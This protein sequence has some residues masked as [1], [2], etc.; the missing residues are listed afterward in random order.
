M[1]LKLLILVLCLQIYSAREA[2]DN[3]EQRA[4][5]VRQSNNNLLLEAAR[6]QN[7]TLRLMGESATVTVNGVDMVSLLRR[8][9]KIIVDRQ[10]AA[11]REPLSVE[12]VKDQFRDVERRMARI[13][14]RVFNARNSTRRSGLKQRTLRQQLQKVERVSGILRTLSA[15]LAKN[16]CESNPC[17]NG[18]TC[19]DAY[20]G[21]QCE[22][23]AGWQGVTCEDDVNECFT[24]AGT[25]L[26]GC[27]N[28]GQCINTPGSY[29][30]ICRNGFSG[31]HCRLRHNTCWASGSRELC[32][33]HGTCL[34]ASNSAGYVCICDQGWTWADPNAT[35]ASPSACTRDVD[36]CEPRVNPCHDVCINLPGSFRCGPCPPGYTGDGRFCQDIDECAGEDNGGCS[37]EPRVTC[38]NTEGSHR[39][40][41]CPIGWTGDGRTCTARNSNSCDQEKIC[42]PLAKCEYVSDTVVCTC[43]LGSYGHGYGAEGCTSDSGRLPCDQHPC[44]NNGTCVQNGRGTTC[45]CQPGYMGALCNSSD[46]CHHPS[47]CLNGGT[48]RLL[49]E[50]K[51]QCVCPRGYTGTTC[52]HQRFFCGNT[53]HGPSG[54][55]HYPP[56][57]AD[58]GYQADER[59]PFIIRT[60]A[61]MVLNLTFTQFE[62]QDSAD[63]SADF[64][65]LHD[66]GS[67]STRLIGRFCGS[68]LPGGNGTVI[69]TQEQVFF[70]FRSDNQTQGKGF[71]VI[72]NSMPFAC[73]ESI[74]MRLSQTG[75]VRSPGYPGKSRPGL[76]CRWLLTAPFGN[77]LILRF[78]DISLGSTE[79]NCTQ[80]SLIVYDSDRQLLRA[81][82]SIQPAPLYSSSNSL[83]LD[84][85]T[86]ALRADS[87]FQMHYEVVP[88]QPG[89][90][91][92]FTESRGHIR[93]FIDAE[94][95]LYLIEQPR[96]TQVKLVI[97]EANLRSCL[98]QNI[99]IYDGR[100][101]DSPLLQ[102]VCG[103]VNDGELEPL[104]STGNVMLVRYQYA[105]AG[106]GAGIS[107]D[108]SYTRVCSGSFDGSS[109]VISTPNYP[110]PYPDDMICTYNLTG[111]L[112]TVAEIKVTDL[113]LGSA[114]NAN[115]TT[116]LDVYLSRDERRHIVKSTDNLVLM[117]HVNR[118]SLVFRGSGSGRGL[119]L[120]YKFLPSNCGGFLH[121]PDRRFI[122][123]VY[124]S[125]CQFF[126]D[127]PGRKRI[128]F[129]SIKSMNKPP[130]DI[131][132]YDNSTSPG[133]LLNRYSDE[134]HDAFD[135]DLLTINLF[136]DSGFG[137]AMISFDIIEQGE[138]GGTFT[139]HFGY[140]RSPNWPKIYGAS[141]KCEWIIRAPFGHRLELVVHNFTLEGGYGTS[142]CLAD[143]LEIRN[144]DSKSSPL[145]GRYC[146]SEIPSRL[147]SFG[148]A[149][150]LSFESD[151]SIEKSGFL[152][153]WQQIGAG[154]GGKLNSPTGSIHSPH[155]LEG[156]RGVLACDW[157]I[158][159]AEGSRVNLQLESSDERLCSGQLTIYDGP[160]T[161]SRPMVMRCNGTSAQPLQSTGN[162]I[163]VRYDVSEE[164]GLLDG[165]DFVLDYQTDCRV[166]LEGLHGA[167]ETPNFPENYPA[168][169]NCEWDIRAGGRKNHLQL[170]LSHLSLEGSSSTCIDSVILIDMLD[171]QK[172][173]EKRLCNE[174]NLANITTAG[175]RLL[176]R[177][178]SDPS[179]QRQ[180][181]RAEYRRMGCGEHFQDMGTN[182]ESPKAPFSVD[183]D[184]V[185]VITASE[186]QQIRLILH[187]LHFEAPQMDCS[188]A[189]SSLSLSA[190][191]GFNSSVVLYRSC[192]EETQ[193]QTFLSPGNELDVHFVSSSVPSRKYFKASY[194]QVPASCGGHIVASNGMITT[195][196]FH[197]LQDSSNVANY[198]TN[199]ECV[200]TVQVTNGY[201][202]GLRF[203]QFNLT[204]S[205][206]C[207][208]S[209]VELTKL[210]A[211]GS[212]RLLESACGEDS[213]MIRIV[214][215]QQ[216]RVRFKAQA[217]TWGR[218]AMYFERQCGGPLSTG[219]GYL[220]SR[221]DEDCSWLISSPEGSK[222][223]LNINQL[224]C[225]KCT[226]V[227]NNCSEGLKLLND[228]DQVVLYQMCRDHPANL[229]VPA[230]NVRILTQG[231]RLQAQYSTFENSCG[232]KI[233]SARG[234]LS[235]PNY[236]DSYP[237]NIECAWT[238][239]TRPGNALEVTFEAMDIVRSE[240]C[241]ADFLELRSGVQGQLLGLYCD[242]KLPE[243]PLVVR[244]ELWI[245]FRSRPANTAGGFRLRWNYVHEIE[246]TTATNGTIEPPP[247]I[248]VKGEDQPFTWRLFTE[249]GNVLVLQFEEYIA[250][251]LL[252]NGFDE[253]AVAVDIAAS[254]W[255]FTS[256]SNVVFLKTV[257]AE[258]SD[259]RVKWHVLD[260]QLVVGNL[261]L[262]SSDCT[263]ELTM[264]ELSSMEITSPG[265]PLGYATNL[266]CEWIIKPEQPSQHIYAYGFKVDLEDFPNCAADYLQ[267]QSSSDLSH[268][269][270]EMRTCK[271]SSAVIAP[272]H[273]TPNLRI[274]FHS[275]VS[276]NG[277]GFS[278]RLRTHCGSNMTGSVG[279][280]SPNNLFSEC[281]WHI[282]VGPGRKIDITVKY[283]G[284]PSPEC[285]SY[286]LIYDGLDDHAPLLE[287]RKFSNQQEFRKRQFR[288]NN[289][290]A[291]IKYHI[292]NSRLQEQC[293]WTLTYRE[294]NECNGEIQLTQQ[295]P[296]YT[297]MSPGYPYLPHP[298]AECTWLVMAPVGETI[299]AN[300]EEPFELS[301]RHCDQENVE[302]FD[303]STQ[304][305][306]SLIRTCHK[307]QTTIRT[308]GNLLLVHYQTQLSEPNGGFR[309][310]LSLSKCGGQFG[311]YS[312]FISSENYPNLGGYPKPSVCEYS[313]R[314][315]KD[316]FIR[317]NIT[318]LHLPFDSN[319]TSSK[320]TS[321]RLEIVDFADPT[322]E[323][324]ILDGSTVTPNL[325]T[326]NTN[327][328]II[329]FVAI[330]NVNK[331]RG[332]KLKYQRALGTCSRDING[333][334]GDIVIPPMPPTTWLRFCRLTIN[335]PK[336]QKVRLSL[337]N[338]ADIRVIIRND[339]ER[340][341]RGLARL[342]SMPHFSFYNDANSLSKITEFRI[343]GYNGSG[344][345]ES[346]D[347]FML[348]VVMTNQLDFSATALRA[349]YSSS[350]AS[351][352]PP[353]IGDQASGSLSIQTLLQ[354]P[355]YHCT[356]H[357]TSTAS[358]TLTFKVEE[359]L[360]Q[361]IGGPAVVFR[362]DLFGSPVKGMYANVTNSFVS[363]ATTAGRVTLLNSQ[364]VKLRRFRATYR[365]H[366]CGGRL[367]A[368]DG[369][370]IQFASTPN[371][372]EL[373]CLW[374]L[375]DSNGYV[376][377][378]N[379]TLSDRCDREYLVIFS[380]Q[381]E[382]SR[383]CRGMTMNSTLLERPYSK[384]IYHSDGPLPTRS[385]FILQATRSVS[386]GNVIRVSQRPSPA[387]TIGSSDYLKSKERIWEFATEDGLSLKLHFLNRIFIVTSPNCTDDRL[388]VERFDRMSGA[389]VEV[390]SLCGRPEPNDI[391]VQSS[392]M[393]VVFRTNSSTPGDG[394]S[395]QVSPSCDAVLQA[396]TEIQTLASPGWA[397]SRLQFNCSYVIL[398]SEEHQL[399]ASVKSRGRPWEPYICSRSYFE[400]Y[401][402]GDREAKEEN[403][404]RFCPEFEVTG[405]GR[406]RLNYLSPVSRLF[407]LQYHLISCGGNYSKPFTLRP[408]QDEE[409]G[410]AYAHNLK[411][412]WRVTAP[413]QHAIV[414]EF[415][416]FD[417]ESSRKCQFDSLTIYRGKV[418][419]EEQRTEQLCGNL[420][421]P[422]AIMV[423]SNEALIALSTDSSNSHRGFLAT[424]RFTQ[425]C[426]ERVNLDLEQPRLNF[427]RL[428]TVN[429]S[430]PLLCHFQASVP[431]DY[432]LSLEVRK[433]QLNDVTC[434]TCSYLEILDS[435]AGEEQSLGKYYGNT[436]AA[437]LNRT[438]VFSSYSEL[439]FHLSA[440]TRRSQMNISFE[441]I[442]KMERSIC[443]Q[444]EY[445][446]RLKE[447]KGKVE[448]IRLGLQHD[449]T[450]R[451]Y[452]GNIQCV[453]T[454]KAD[455]D[456]ELDFQKLR[457]KE[458]SQR[459]GECEDYLKLSKP[460]FTRSFC[461]QHDKSFKMIESVDVSNLQLTFH[462]EVL[463]ESQGFEV[464][465]RPK[466]N[467]N[468]TYTELSAV[469]DAS[470]LNNCTEYIRVPSGYSITLYIMSISFDS[471][472]HNYFN[473][474]DLKSN[475]TI[476]S[477]S[478]M[479]WE[480]AARITTTNELRL[481]SSGVSTLKFFYFSTSNDFPGGCGGDLA[482]VGSMGSYLENPS[483]EGRNSSLCTW[484]ISVPPGGNLQFSFSEFNMGSETNCDLD[485]V[486]FFD[487]GTAARTLLKTICGSSIPN[488][489]T[490]NNNKIVI[491]AKKSPNFDGLGFKMDIKQ[492]G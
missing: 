165:T 50:N 318:D 68:R 180:G 351:V 460:Y 209:S 443:G 118:A 232:G 376:L 435:D 216:L 313:I 23:S 405:Y 147:P 477:T 171:E 389:F 465:I 134:V 428:Y 188:N 210:E 114:N 305:S 473:V 289:S 116:Y 259:F 404:G 335:V 341:I 129:H 69:T 202:I 397:A 463:E 326:L 291:Y 426:N 49:P 491:I 488:D 364:N 227:S 300:F 133:I 250:G 480:T 105:L 18:G 485:N 128:N 262:T 293:L 394:F 263:K 120:E 361:T 422:R 28:N 438:K 237:A 113:S 75:V 11:R 278:A 35:A 86:D 92:V 52:S 41:R 77:R 193:S 269:T 183:M 241:N 144:G 7:V 203:D 450:T 45:I 169:L 292:G 327:A 447:G 355:N 181:F 329:R 206:N 207:S 111:P 415:K 411:C 310:N 441:L 27:Q 78:Y 306:R 219:E 194:V 379:V 106:L 475:K 348:V 256:S 479:R 290:H 323:L 124:S 387:V 112:D 285:S 38:T 440:S 73:G 158:A 470:S 373:E 261:S 74:Y 393:R 385:E 79:T 275:D 84:F 242:N 260:S 177:F 234:S 109:G 3:L 115:E 136:K 391:L 24:L 360:F 138:C 130:W 344:I 478:E 414:I 308:S 453:W 72:W 266:N 466:P 396:G 21:F 218:F 140:I 201:G 309:L 240:H 359:Y 381:L 145:I 382:V 53:I 302:L 395:F 311:G 249:R 321:D 417:M 217:G 358:T 170:V 110:G 270:N 458:I 383:I 307:P 416:Y 64:L 187:E 484:N 8:R 337:L 247:P 214:H 31:T 287:H 288:T 244:S 449:N 251:L 429:V 238:I 125:F 469:I 159:V 119:R 97:N 162:R 182:F 253:S 314:L 315:P 63:C 301:A 280:I 239:E 419:S 368:A 168:N 283:N 108:W 175:N 258:L 410:G 252:I 224:E 342:R 62:L 448:D 191:S 471:F 297:V 6:D 98:L 127:V 324:L 229:I 483:Y 386:S 67:L 44:Q 107:Y 57:A 60:T 4:R 339:T 26:A 354:L 85:H 102:R 442:L 121:E 295:A 20:K 457:L 154:C 83:R 468:R 149:L 347:N 236:P 338:L 36:E 122:K 412:E 444:T 423:N 375:G 131:V 331:Y 365:R 156:N 204:D 213:P 99:E 81:C 378:G 464:I 172:L 195:P 264:R 15:N 353:N 22:C 164:E 33:D 492:T 254:P 439:S 420:T 34:Q 184:C 150:H 48:C 80:D 54:Q 211:E 246:V 374:N 257:N 277:T 345:I 319:G 100:T 139:G 454:I 392:R 96:G 286:G 89:C 39:C 282:D 42:H 322:Q 12:V 276:F 200:W 235:S 174:D 366:D 71:H 333:A 437:N 446:L 153:N 141:E 222:L 296:N 37:L 223:S 220:Q 424:V 340:T 198:S 363:L 2:S 456:V 400:T 243:S 228:D 230:N 82:Q 143:W 215:G 317:L 87:S 476:F 403:H 407:E 336:G 482:V 320:E 304:L 32:G 409:P 94:E 173:S 362:D 489:F 279:T 436:G 346:T 399:V 51:Y 43:P 132:I 272:V 459:T 474:T 455:G 432:R 451:N 25:D 350:E 208:L 445:D 377:E 40:G 274:Q 95:C 248:F 30:C 190:P 273:G 151:T 268:W 88:G 401:R 199:V 155:L 212:E 135:G 487:N 123:R 427:M 461:G 370:T 265:Y 425:N 330:K 349:R 312:G 356:I 146:G 152:L 192:H 384:I 233:T 176:L 17:Q 167:I 267:V 186:G 58:G 46:A 5:L 452:E 101:T 14:R 334:D 398:A 486:Q 70:W 418:A 343:D 434:R 16:E 316:Q 189:D 390:T 388:T 413:P 166:R 137:M 93:G 163:L 367:Q 490:F 205:T 179:V 90:G 332:F 328:A 160:T 281:A 299:A 372:G 408:P 142:N 76:D 433:L 117:S 197:N 380:G 59:C 303:G 245:K 352:C 29:R 357:F 65:Q 406:I 430:E 255:T 225:P 421:N 61:N 325:V 178:K 91:G 157:Q 47:P 226:A 221:L 19:H 66:G 10:A 104:I 13:Q 271:K 161:A 369:I 55:L 298:H 103:I 56:S 1:I 431:P 481:D 126:I 462:S 467:C 9:Q 196:G 402:R 185:W 294:F 472:D 284:P 148:N 231:I 371:D